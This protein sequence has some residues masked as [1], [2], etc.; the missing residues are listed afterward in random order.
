MLFANS[1]RYHINLGTHFFD[2]WLF[3]QYVNWAC[4]RHKLFRRYLLRFHLFIASIFD[5]TVPL[6]HLAYSELEFIISPET[7]NFLELGPQAVARNLQTQFVILELV[8]TAAVDYLKL[9]VSVGGHLAAQTDMT[10]SNY[11][12]QFARVK[13]DCGRVNLHSWRVWCW[14]LY[15]NFVGFRGL[16]IEYLLLWIWIIIGK[17]VLFQAYLV[18]VWDISVNENQ[19]LLREW[20]QRPVKIVNKNFFFVLE[21]HFLAEILAWTSRDVLWNSTLLG[22]WSSFGGKHYF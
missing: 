19:V 16:W 2:L 4:F 10:D 11:V 8:T 3:E 20:E 12:L 7:Q 18:K 15:C 1:N 6:S 14:N 13:L 17:N 22:A 5:G 21:S 9:T